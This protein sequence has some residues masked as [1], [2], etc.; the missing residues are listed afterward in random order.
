[1]EDSFT[2]NFPKRWLNF[3]S[4]TDEETKVD[5][6][7]WSIVS[8]PLHGYARIDERGLEASYYP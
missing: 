5:E 6:L 3:F 1:M 7:T 4:V 2:E 8:S